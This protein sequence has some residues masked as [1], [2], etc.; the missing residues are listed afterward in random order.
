MGGLPWL[1]PSPFLGKEGLP[2]LPPF[3]FLA[4]GDLPWLPP[5]PFLGKEGLPGFLPSSFLDKGGLPI[6]LFFFS[7]A[8]ELSGEVFTIAG[9]LWMKS[10]DWLE[11]TE[12][13]LLF[14]D[15]DRED[16]RLIGFGGFELSISRLS[17]LV[18]ISKVFFFRIPGRSEFVSPVVVAG[19]L[20]DLQGTRFGLSMAFPWQSKEFE[21]RGRVHVDFSA[22]PLLSSGSLFFFSNSFPL[23][24][25]F[26]LLLWLLWVRFFEES[27]EI[28]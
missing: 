18:S 14:F 25:F 19:L 16:L 15:R 8:I 2:G 11:E 5:S 7:R 27:V 24:F 1:L 13:W 22:L 17:F 12:L 20:V 10:D 9:A 21:G 6:K 4:I 28:L 3:S 26:V 23:E